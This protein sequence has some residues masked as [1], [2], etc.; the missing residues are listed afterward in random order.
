MDLENV[1]VVHEVHYHQRLLHEAWMPEKDPKAG[2]DHIVIP[3]VYKCLRW[4]YM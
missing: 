3:E 2:N 1:E 4:T